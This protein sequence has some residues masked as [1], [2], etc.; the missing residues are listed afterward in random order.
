M[1]LSYIGILGFLAAARCE[2]RNLRV[3]NTVPLGTSSAVIKK[4]GKGRHKVRYCRC[5]KNL[6]DCSRPTKMTEEQEN[7]I[8]GPSDFSWRN[9]NRIDSE[10]TEDFVLFSSPTHHGKLV[11]WCLHFDPQ[12]CGQTAA[13][14]YCDEKD[15]GPAVDFLKRRT[16]GKETLTM[17]EHST[18]T[19]EDNVCIAFEFIACSVL[20]QT[21]ES[22]VMH[23]YAL[24]DCYE[25]KKQCQ[26]EA[27]DA[28]C[29]EN[30]YVKAID[31]AKVPAEELTMTI[32]DH[33]ICNPEW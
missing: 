8:Q 22:P 18:C 1:K 16:Y 5:G 30:G 28:F 2:G 25:F 23:E 7:R 19:P 31:Y 33:A 12:D 20:E 15:Q 9:S 14:L 24:D 6:C 10:N 11:D 13:D 4:T 27:A 17:D 21:Y 29:Q 26:S 32:G 3:P